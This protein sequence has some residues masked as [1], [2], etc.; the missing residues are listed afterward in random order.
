VATGV[1]EIAPTPALMPGLN[2]PLFVLA[3]VLLAVG[4]ALEVRR[5]WIRRGLC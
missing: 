5:G 2:T 3:L 1:V 4:A